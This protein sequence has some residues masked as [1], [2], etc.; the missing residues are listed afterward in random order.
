MLLLFVY[1]CGLSYYY[2]IRAAHMMLYMHVRSFII[3]EYYLCQ[4]PSYMPSSHLWSHS[5]VSHLHGYGS[6]RIN[7]FVYPIVTDKELLSIDAT[8]SSNR[9]W[10]LTHAMSRLDTVSCVDP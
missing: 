5:H 4:V 6:K 2:N 3:E 8:L 9:V 1:V 10:E 7:R